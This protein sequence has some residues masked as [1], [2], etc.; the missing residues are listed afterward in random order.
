MIHVDRSSIRKPDFWDGE[1]FRAFLDDWAEF[2]LGGGTAVAQKRASTGSRF[3][4][5][6]FRQ[7]ALPVLLEGFHFKCA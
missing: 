1:E 6:H 3:D 7:L 4:L 2:H 5:E